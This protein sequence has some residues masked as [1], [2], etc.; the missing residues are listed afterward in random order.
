MNPQRLTV[1]TVFSVTPAVCC[2]YLRKSDRVAHD[3]NYSGE[4]KS[5]FIANLQKRGISLLAPPCACDPSAAEV[6]KRI[7]AA[8]DCAPA[9]G[10]GMV[11]HHLWVIRGILADIDPEVDLS[12]AE[13]LALL[14]T[15]APVHARVLARR[16]AEFQPRGRPPVLDVVR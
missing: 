15:L 5:V 12:P 10:A 13:L 14:A 6:K 16:A 7:N 3:G 11:H 2:T 8:L 4:V 9:T 1:V